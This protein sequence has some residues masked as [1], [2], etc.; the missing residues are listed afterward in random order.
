MNPRILFYVQHLMGVGHVFRAMR[1]VRALA[2]HGAEV[3]VIYGGEPV[4][5]MNPGGARVHYLPPLRGGRVEFHLL[6]KPDGAI[7]DESYKSDRR[8]RILSILNGFKPDAIVVEAFPFG[9][10]QMRFEL[11]P[12]L[13]QAN[14]MRPK[15]LVIC[16]VRDILQ[17]R[18]KPG[19]H[20]ETLGH[21]DRYFDQI[22]V[23]GD[24]NMVQLAETFPPAGQIRGKLH[25]TGIVAPERDELDPEAEAF[26]VIVTV[27]AGM[28]GR[29]LLEAT[30]RA[31]AKTPLADARWLI[32]TGLRNDDGLT[33]EIAALAGENCRIVPF[34]NDLV[35]HL[36]RT[37]LSISRCGYNTVA[38]VLVAGC[39]A[40]ML[41]LS[42]GVETEQLKRAEILARGKLATVLFP[43]H[44]TPEAIAQAIKNAMTKKAPNRSHIEIGG[45]RKS[46]ELIMSW[47]AERGGTMS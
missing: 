43:E 27:G 1:I 15:P 6:E 35:S 38:D 44:E 23:H 42:D 36:A 26:D 2:K 18:T 7:A 11:L 25:Y 41:P 24:P 46:A 31:K 13:D 28:L 40:I 4:P 33:S 16:S 12:M 22:L 34:V 39:R 14:V 10:R 20:E 32:A 21:L 5:G 3:E 19:R 8:D 45:A 37:E 29:K 30:V 47:L 9:R 17:E